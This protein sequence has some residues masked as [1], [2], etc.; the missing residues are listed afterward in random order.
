MVALLLGNYGKNSRD[1]SGNPVQ[2][3]HGSTK[4]FIRKTAVLA[5][6]FICFVYLAWQGIKA[7]TP[8]LP[9][10]DEFIMYF[11]TTWIAG[12]FHTAEWN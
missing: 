1:W 3:K 6:V 4:L 2:T 5:F 11:E 8:E 9:R 10:I 12:I 7:D